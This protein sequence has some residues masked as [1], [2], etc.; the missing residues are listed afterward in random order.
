MTNVPQDENFN[1]NLIDAFF[2]AVNSDTGLGSDG[3]RFDLWAKPLE[4]FNWAQEYIPGLIVS[5]AGGAVPYQAEGLINGYPFYYR[6]EWGGCSILIGHPDKEIPYL[7]D[8]ALWLAV[9]NDFEGSTHETFVEALTRL[10]PI[11]EKTPRLFKFPCYGHDF[12]ENVEPRWQWVIKKD[13]TAYV[14]GIGHTVEEAYQ[15]AEKPSDYLAEHGFSFENQIEFF[16]AKNPSRE[17]LFKE[18]REYPLVP[19]TFHSTPFFAPKTG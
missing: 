3:I 5:S 14:Q 11:L 6:S 8:E 12:L 19:L 16:H 17:P 2:D 18:P 13:E 7:W 1:Q 10:L 4:A 15:N 9:D